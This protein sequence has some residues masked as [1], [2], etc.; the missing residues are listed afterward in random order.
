MTFPLLIVFLAS[1]KSIGHGFWRKRVE[2]I[3]E[4]QS[5]NSQKPF[6][7]RNMSLDKKATIIAT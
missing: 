7:R 5:A 4:Q 1:W 2:N 6:I 3:S